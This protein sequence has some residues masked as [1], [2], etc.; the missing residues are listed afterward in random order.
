MGMYNEKYKR[1]S[2]AKRAHGRLFLKEFLKGRTEAICKVYRA[3]KS[4]SQAS[5]ARQ[6]ETDDWMPTMQRTLKE[7]YPGN[8][9]QFRTI[10]C[11]SCEGNVPG[12]LQSLRSCIDV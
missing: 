10:L 12:T 6:V 4:A 2:H 3:G 8:H 5:K 9:D 7:P 1:P 11:W